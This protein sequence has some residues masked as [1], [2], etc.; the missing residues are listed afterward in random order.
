MRG[1]RGAA[2]VAG[3]AAGLSA[4]TLLTSLDGLAG[5]PDE[6]NRPDG[7]VLDAPLEGSGSADAGSDGEAGQLCGFPGPTDGLLAYYAFE[8]GAGSTVHDCT[9]SHFDGTFVRQADGGNWAPGK[10]GGAIRVLAP[11]GCVE[12]GAPLQ[13]RPPTMTVAVWVNVNTFPAV[14]AAGYVIGQALNADVNGWR[15]GSHTADGGQVGWLH[16]NGGTKYVYDTP[17]PIGSWHHYAMTFK[18]NGTL[19]I[20]VDAARTFTQ[21]G[22]PP[23]VFAAVSLRIGCRAD[24]TNYLDGMIDELRIY[25]RVLTGPEIATLASP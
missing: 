14:G 10:K 9:G 3:L 2:R 5:S 18:P 22:V 13:L 11:N 23:I 7:Q 25:D 15:I 1:M 16:A 19:E 12:L 6:L 17:S 21:N 20:F 4:C 8:E 24:D